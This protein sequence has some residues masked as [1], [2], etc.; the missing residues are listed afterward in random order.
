MK[1]AAKFRSIFL[2]FQF[3][4]KPL[5]TRFFFIFIVTILKASFGNNEQHSQHRKALFNSILNVFISLLS[6]RELPGGGC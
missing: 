2:L 5:F 4:Q 6:A 1:E 3:I